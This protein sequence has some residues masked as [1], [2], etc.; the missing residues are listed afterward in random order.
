M[1]TIPQGMLCT[2]DIMPSIMQM[3]YDYHDM[4]ALTEIMV[5]P[6]VSVTK[7]DNDPVVSLPHDWAWGLE[8]SGL[9]GLI[10][11]PHFGRLV[12]ANTCV[13]KLLAYFHRGYQ[14]LDKLV[15]I[16]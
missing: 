2:M 5:D 16:T 13:K 7:A 8:R 4:L 3:K 1:S 14:W 11:M 9:L 10:N 15:P 6:F 12:E